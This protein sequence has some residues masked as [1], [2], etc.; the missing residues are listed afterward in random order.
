MLFSFA[1]CLLIKLTLFGIFITHSYS[2]AVFVIKLSS[3]ISFMANGHHTSFLIKPNFLGRS[4][5]FLPGTK[6][7][8][9]TRASN[10]LTIFVLTSQPY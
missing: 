7:W 10:Y 1:H 8:P 2:F 6:A 9:L 4:F 5:K 3:L